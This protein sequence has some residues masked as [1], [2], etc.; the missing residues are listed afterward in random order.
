M[1]AAD[2]LWVPDEGR[3]ASTAMRAFADE[4]ARRYGV[5]RYDGALHAWSVASPEQFWPL[6]W[7]QCGVVGDRGE[8]AEAHGAHGRGARPAAV[9]KLATVGQAVLH[10]LGVERRGGQSHGQ[11]EPQGTAIHAAASPRIRRGNVR[12]V[13]FA[14]ELRGPCSWGIGG[15]AAPAGG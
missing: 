8:V 1:A 2:P 3:I 4:A 9:G 6:V 10:R 12:F 5:A 14:P 11:H 7:E 15:T 13:T